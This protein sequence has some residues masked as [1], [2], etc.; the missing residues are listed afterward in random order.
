M[1]YATLTYRM[2]DDAPAH[3]QVCWWDETPFLTHFLRLLGVAGF[4]ATLRFGS[5]PVRAG[6]RKL[7]AQE[8]QAAM[9][10]SF[11]PMS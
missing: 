10:R 5:E 4:E 9:A 3:H 8:L 2:L 1:Y 11:T 7:L 6:D